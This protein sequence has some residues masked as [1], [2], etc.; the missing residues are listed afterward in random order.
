MIANDGLVE[1]I[2]EY[3]SHR[4]ETFDRA[5]GHGI[6]PGQEA[7]AWAR[8]MREHL[9]PAPRRVLELACGTGEVT[10]LIHDLGH[11][12]T[13]LDFCEPML[14]KAR[15]KHAGKPRLRFVHADAGRTMEPD[16]RYDAVVCRHLV[17]TLTD[18]PAA[19]ADW[20]RILRPGGRLLVYDGD[21]TRP[22]PAGG[23]A[24]WILARWEKFAPDAYYD[25]AMNARCPLPSCSGC[26]SAKGLRS[27]ASPR[28]CAMPAL[29]AFASCPMHRFPGRNAEDRGC[30]TGCAPLS[31]GASS[32]LPRNPADPE[33]TFP[34]SATTR[35]VLGHLNR[36][37]PGRKLGPAGDP[38]PGGSWRGWLA[39]VRPSS[40]R[41]G[42]AGALCQARRASP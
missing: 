20:V 17:W 19:F 23:S 10:R 31:T 9:G 42:P 39:R 32:S 14:A 22:A 33:R 8:P 3:W 1:D 29:P 24:A 37:V 27:T 21:W 6:A 25:G 41:A 36:V 40:V 13:G 11:D 34:C 4:A 35:K 16:A 7:A 26:R 38:G 15:A 28:C 12:V 5:F 18:P 2:R 30:A